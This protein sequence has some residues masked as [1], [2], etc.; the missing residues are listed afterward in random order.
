MNLISK[1]RVYTYILTLSHW[2]VE[3]EKEIWGWELK[4]YRKS[5]K[6]GGKVGKE[7][8]KKYYCL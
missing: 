8:L 1:A 3:K 4:W 7:M 6:R 5:K 2:Y